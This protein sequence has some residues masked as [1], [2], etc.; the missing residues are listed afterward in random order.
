LTEAW[1]SALAGLDAVLCPATAV[2]AQPHSAIPRVLRSLLV[3]DQSYPFDALAAWSVLAS[4]GHQPS[5]TLPAGPGAGT[6][7][8]VG[9]Q[10][11]G[12]FRD[13]AHL[14]AVAAAVDEILGGWASPPGW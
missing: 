9:L 8:P 13:D 11:V 10:L 3:D 6:G 7:L 4:V 12:R 1:Q 14:L 2:V 5:V